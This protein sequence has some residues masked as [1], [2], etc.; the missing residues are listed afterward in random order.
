MKNLLEMYAELTELYK[1]YELLNTYD[2]LGLGKRYH[3]EKNMEKLESEIKILMGKGINKDEPIFWAKEYKAKANA[4]RNALVMMR[5]LNED[6]VEF[7]TDLYDTYYQ[8]G[9]MYLMMED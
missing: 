6:V 5:N 4:I 7:L 8:K 9:A 1:Y 2:T 3:A